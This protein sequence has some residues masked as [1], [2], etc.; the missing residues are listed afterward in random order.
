ML[1]SVVI[2]VLIQGL[3]SLTAAQ[4]GA[5]FDIVCTGHQRGRIMDQPIDGELENRIAI[6]LETRQWCQQ[7]CQRIESISVIEPGLLTLSD[8]T[9]RVGSETFIDRVT[10]DRRTGAYES[11]FGNDDFGAIIGSAT[12]ERAEFTPFPAM[13]F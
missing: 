3:P 8:R 11:Y 4:D 6:N 9:K 13:R 5:A 2:A 1:K 10:L 12:C 7:P